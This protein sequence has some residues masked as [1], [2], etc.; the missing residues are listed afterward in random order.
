MESLSR[1]AQKQ[2][3]ILSVKTVQSPLPRP[4]VYKVYTTNTPDT[5]CTPLY[6][7]I[8]T[9]AS[10]VAIKTANRSPKSA[11]SAPPRQPAG[12]GGPDQPDGHLTGAPDPAYTAEKWIDLP[13]RK[14]YRAIYPRSAFFN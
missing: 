13:Y 5:T 8:L 6:V 10:D 4:G 14:L 9:S 1:P 2:V 12:R 3:S 11:D 7:Q